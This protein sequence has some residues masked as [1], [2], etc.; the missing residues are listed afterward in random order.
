[1][2]QRPEDP[3]FRGKPFVLFLYKPKSQGQD[4]TPGAGNRWDLYGY[5]SGV[6][7]IVDGKVYR[8]MQWM[9]PDP[10]IS[11]WTRGA[12]TIRPELSDRI[13]SQ[14]TAFV[15]CGPEQPQ[16]GPAIAALRSMWLSTKTILFWTP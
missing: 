5:G 12:H 13:G 3:S 15:R 4:T 11:S 14:T 1:V 6:R 10:T 7:W 2:P 8:Y 16:H 9:N